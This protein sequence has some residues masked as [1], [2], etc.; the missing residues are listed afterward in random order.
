[1]SSSLAGELKPMIPPLE[2]VQGMSSLQNSESS[3]RSGG[4]GEEYSSPPDR[5]TLRDVH[6]VA[7]V[8][9][10][11]VIGVPHPKWTERPLL[12]VVRSPG[13]KVVKEEIL[14]FLQVGTAPVPI[15][16]DADTINEARTQRG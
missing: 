10:A 13:S 8:L 15:Y 14:N 7:Q 1:M 2:F 11:A 3:S 4:A 12:V 6:L 9:E 16:Q 5:H